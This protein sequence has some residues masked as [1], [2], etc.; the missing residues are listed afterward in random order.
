MVNK[1]HL[2]G[3]KAARQKTGGKNRTPA[4]TLPHKEHNAA[5]KEQKKKGNL[6]NKR[7]PDLA[8]R[9]GIEESTSKIFFFMCGAGDPQKKEEKCVA[10][11]ETVLPGG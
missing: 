5:R 9:E 4:R 1:G 11:M 7:R 10:T 6:G 2:K 8:P 3:L